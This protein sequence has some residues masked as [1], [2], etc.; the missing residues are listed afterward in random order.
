MF[1]YSAVLVAWEDTFVLVRGYEGAK[2]SE[3][4]EWGGMKYERGRIYQEGMLES[5]IDLQIKIKGS[6]YDVGKKWTYD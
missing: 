5:W 3:R 6:E 1:V 2:A 4:C